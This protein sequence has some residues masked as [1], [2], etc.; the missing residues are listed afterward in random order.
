MAGNTPRGGTMPIAPPGGP[1]MRY[2]PHFMMAL[3]GAR[4]R[5]PKASIRA[6]PQIQKT[7]GITSVALPRMTFV[8]VR[9]P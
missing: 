5:A 8:H 6:S 9:R 2:M 3:A 1:V 4:G 7:L